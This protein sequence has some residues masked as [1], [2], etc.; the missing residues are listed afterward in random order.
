[1]NVKEFMNYILNLG[2]NTFSGIPDSTL[3]EFC[4]ELNNYNGASI[5]HFVTANEG[6]AVGL[7]AGVYLATGKPAC[8]YMQN[9]GIG[10]AVN[11]LTSIANQEVY[12]IPM[13]LVVG[14]RGEP[15][16]KDEPQHKF[17]G[18]ITEEM[19]RCLEINYGIIGRDSTSEE[20]RHVFENA[21]QALRSNHQ[22]TIIVKRGTFTKSE[23]VYYRNKYSLSRETAISEIVKF[24]DAEDIIVSTTGKISRE[25]FEES[26]AIYQQHIQDFLTVGG[27]GHASMIAFGIAL[28]RPNKQVYCLDGDG[29][30]LMHMGSLGIMGNYPVDNLIHVCLNN[31]AHESVGGMPT[32][33]PHLEFSEIARVCGYSS[34]FTVLTSD[35]LISALEHCRKSRGLTFIEVKVSLDSRENLGRPKESAVQNK[36]NFMSYH[37]VK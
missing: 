6:A 14:W 29:A 31:N 21:D 33:A 3:K 4:T 9:S 17:M 10:N 30:L 32:G 34:I 37:G 19:L 26:D 12:E 36:I 18:R 35:E 13:L 11:P 2:I 1:M 7:A 24:A 5:K 27:M 22:Y 28:S 16:I 20:I 8:V 15:G 23:R 25:L